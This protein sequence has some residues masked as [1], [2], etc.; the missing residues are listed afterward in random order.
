M[1]TRCLSSDRQDDSR[2]RLGDFFDRPHL[3]EGWH[4]QESRVPGSAEAPPEI[5]E[6]PVGRIADVFA[7]VLR[8]DYRLA[9]RGELPF[10][11]GP[12][13]G[14]LQLLRPCDM[15][16]ARAPATVPF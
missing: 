3:G 12:V 10:H 2:D 6:A 16:Q 5:Q 8:M 15:P 7:R 9:H 13:P 11:L 1:A 14:P 4:V